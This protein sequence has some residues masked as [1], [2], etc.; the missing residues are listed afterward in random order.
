LLVRHGAPAGD[1]G[2]VPR[3]VA[4]VAD[5]EGAGQGRRRSAVDQ[6]AVG[7]R[8]GQPEIGAV[9]S[10]VVDAPFFA[11]LMNFSIFKDIFPFLKDF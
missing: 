1:V 7:L 2:G 4:R 5:V 3:V 8:S 11:I 10:R 6:G 9:G